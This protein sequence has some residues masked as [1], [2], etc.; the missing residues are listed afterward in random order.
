MYIEDYP[1]YL[2]SHQEQRNFNLV[3][4]RHDEVLMFSLGKQVLRQTALYDRQHEL[5]ET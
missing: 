1:N 2:V 5:K 3:Q 4:K